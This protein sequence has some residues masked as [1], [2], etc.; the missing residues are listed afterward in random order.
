MS[1]MRTFEVTCI[2]CPVG[3]R[4]TVTITD[5]DVKV[6]GVEC[7]RGREYVLKEITEPT[8]DFFTTV[9]VRDGRV[10]VIPVRS[11]QPVPKDRILDC[12]KEAAKMTLEA[13]I[14]VGDT[15]LEDI[16]GLGVDVVATRTVDKKS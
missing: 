14:A 16:L 12:A 1:K 10:P 13:P 9:P 6:E 15:V 2:V 11:T 8:R 3:C 4:A 5:G 7:P